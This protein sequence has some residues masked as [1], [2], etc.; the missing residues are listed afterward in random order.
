MELEEKYHA[1]GEYIIGKIIEETMTKGG[2]HIPGTVDRK[3]ERVE[4]L[5]V[6]PKVDIGIEVGDIALVGKPGLGKLEADIVLFP[7]EYV[8][9]A[10][11]TSRD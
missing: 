3:H 7:Q 2:L 10:E 6:G 1:V 9:A 5:S 8:F 4:V 11:E